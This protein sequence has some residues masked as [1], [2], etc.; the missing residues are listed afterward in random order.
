[1]KACITGYSPKSTVV[2]ALLYLIHRR[3]TDITRL[4]INQFLFSLSLV[5]TLTQGIYRKKPAHA[6]SAVAV[7]TAADTALG[8]C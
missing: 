4:N 6:A 7:A 3:F 5:L 2:T 8:R 1:M